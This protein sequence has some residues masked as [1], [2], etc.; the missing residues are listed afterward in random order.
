MLRAGQRTTIRTGL[1]LAFALAA[2]VGVVLAPTSPVRA[3]IGPSVT[4]SLTVSSATVG[5]SAGS[6]TV[7]VVSNIPAPAAITI[8]VATVA[9]TATTKSDFTAVA[10]TITIAKGATS[11]SVSI[12]IVKNTVREPTETFTVEFSTTLL[13]KP[14]VSKVTITDD[15]PYSSLFSGSAGVGSTSTDRRNAALL[16]RMSFDAYAFP[17]RTAAQWPADVTARYESTAYGWDV[18][19]T[20]DDPATDTQAFALRNSTSYVIV[21]RGSAE[22]LDWLGNFETNRITIP[23]TSAQV[24]SGFWNAAD[25]VYADIVADLA[26]FRGTR[27][28]WVTGHSLGGAVAQLTAFRLRRDNHVPSASLVTFG[29]PSVGSTGFGTLFSSVGSLAYQ[30]WVHLDDPVPYVPGVIGDALAFT[31]N[32][33]ATDLR[34]L[35]D[36]T[37]SAVGG[38]STVT[39]PPTFDLKDHDMPLY[40]GDLVKVVRGA[41]GLTSTAVGQ[42]LPPVPPSSLPSVGFEAIRQALIDN[43]FPPEAI[44]AFVW[45]VEALPIDEIAQILDAIGTALPVIGQILGFVLDVSVATLVGAIRL[46]GATWIEV[47]GIVETVFELA[48]GV[49]AQ[50]MRSLGAAATDVAAA[51]ASAYSL[52]A[53]AVIEAMTAG[54]FALGVAAD[55]VVEALTLTLDQLTSALRLAGATANQIANVLRGT[56][57][58]STTGVAE[59][60]RTAGYG[61]TTIATALV[62][63]FRGIAPDLL[64]AAAR[65]LVALGPSDSALLTALARAFESGVTLDGSLLSNIFRQLAELGYSAAALTVAAR[66]ALS[67]SLSALAEA[68]KNGYGRT[69]TQIATILRTSLS[70]GFASIASALRNGLGISAASVATALRNG[71]SATLLQAASALR[72]AAYSLTTIAS[73]VRSVYDAT[74]LQ[75][76]NALRNAGYSVAAIVSAVRSAYSAGAAAIAS[77]LQ[78]L[79]VSVATAVSAIVGAFGLA[80]DAL[81]SLLVNAGYTAAAV[82]DAA[83]CF[84]FGAC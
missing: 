17:G 38:Q 26:A 23:G 79:G 55:A 59:F 29:A 20:Y 78:D 75:A 5:E 13:V 40:Y 46:I 35:A 52:G 77:V 82:L 60:L 21:F 48:P 12:P 15:D 43:G 1:T 9:G 10:S 63:A 67:S 11:T 30:R 7:S 28:V 50:V 2:P 65:A 27:S 18:V 74:L 76:V 41:L 47:A 19:A 24:H 6:A 49:A 25:S 68:L 22:A 64:D 8:D 61:F 45:L 72:S 56:F 33:L 66:N 83:N 84:F 69:A 53:E 62:N 32:V 58:I 36:G 34:T 16:A 73:A 80:F 51:L 14:L 42:L 81:V 3:A 44:A 4:P 54:G 71:V 39:V 57:T 70:A 31:H 37:V